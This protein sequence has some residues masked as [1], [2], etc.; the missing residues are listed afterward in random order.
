MNYSD[1]SSDVMVVERTSQLT[2][3]TTGV[4]W[5]EIDAEFSSIIGPV[6]IGLCPGET[7][8][9]EAADTFAILLSAHLARR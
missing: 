5:D 9:P 6:H 7:D 8:P 3:L 4:S 1:D 2:E